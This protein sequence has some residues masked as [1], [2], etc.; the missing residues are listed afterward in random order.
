LNVWLFAALTAA[1][2]LLIGSEVILEP[3]S[4]WRGDVRRLRRTVLYHPAPLYALVECAVWVFAL[5]TLADHLSSPRESTTGR[6]IWAITIG[7]HE[8]GHFLCI[9]FGRTLNIAGGSIWQVII[10][11]VPALYTFYLRFEITTSLVFWT[12]TGHSL[13]NLSIYVADARARALPL[14][15]GM[16]K[17]SHDWWN[18]LGH[19][20]ALQYDT[21]IAALM[22][23]TAVLLIVF[24]AALGIITAWLLPR[25]ELSG[26]WGAR[27]FHGN[28]FRDMARVL[29]PPP[30]SPTSAP[31]EED[32]PPDYFFWEAMTGQQAAEPTAETER[33]N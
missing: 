32:L 4:H 8:I 13:I 15:F 7:P 24:S 19:F 26:K 20:H 31:A 1:A 27:R 10:F 30:P 2:V 9:P 22:Q 29:A 11:L 25:R 21:L 3:T 12:M 18:L 16:G 33:D 28:L 5:V 6:I 23:G 14:L 17:D